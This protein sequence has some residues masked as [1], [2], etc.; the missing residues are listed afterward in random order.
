M[1]GRGAAKRKNGGSASRLANLLV[2][3]HA[4]CDY[5]ALPVPSSL[6]TGTCSRG[7]V[8][9]R[10]VNTARKRRTSLPVALFGRVAFV[11][12]ALG[13][14]HLIAAARFQRIAEEPMRN[15]FLSDIS[16][17]FFSLSLFFLCLSL[18]Q[19]YMLAHTFQNSRGFA[20]LTTRLFSPSKKFMVL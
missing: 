14:A 11:V 17:A 1:D 16:Y 8:T 2:D 10:R 5:F 15:H 4:P 6:T 7:R 18:Y 19:L 3:A 9:M 12:R 13:A 20:N